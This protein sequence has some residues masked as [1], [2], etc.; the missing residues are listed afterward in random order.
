MSKYRIRVEMIEGEDGE[1]FD[2][3]FA[4]GIECN[5]FVILGDKGDD[6]CCAI[7]DVNTMRIAEMIAHHS[8]MSAA[9][10][11][12]QA[13]REAEEIKRKGEMEERLARM[14]GGD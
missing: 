13:L 7:H 12:A 3:R 9:A 6:A 11:I 10:V 2:E 8:D 4:E 1:R 14:F 5:G